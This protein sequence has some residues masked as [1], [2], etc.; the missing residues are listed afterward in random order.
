MVV[1]K[2]KIVAIEYSLKD[3]EGLILDSNKG[4]APIEYLHGAGNIL[5]GLEKAIEGMQ[6]GETKLGMVAAEQAY[7]LYDKALQK[8]LPVGLFENYE[9]L[10]EGDAVKLPDGTTAVVIK[11][12]NEKIMVDSNHPLA[13]TVL[14]FEVK[15]TGIRTA[16][17]DELLKGYPLPEKGNCS[18]APG[19]C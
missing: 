2:N 15:V 9:T 18:G 12:E 19:C 16:R 17:E 7:G 3:E 13:G 5:P 1:N 8:E 14:Y 6:T 11:K 4:F 10:Q